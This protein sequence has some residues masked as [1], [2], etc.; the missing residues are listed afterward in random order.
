MCSAVNSLRANSLN[1]LGRAASHPE[2]FVRPVEELTE[3]F[4]CFF[5]TNSPVNEQRA[6]SMPRGKCGVTNMRATPIGIFHCVDQSCD[7]QV[8]QRSPAHDTRFKRGVEAQIILAR[9]AVVALERRTKHDHLSMIEVVRP[10]SLVSARNDLLPCCQNGS[11]RE[12]QL[13]QGPL[14]LLG[15]VAHHQVVKG[16][17]LGQLDLERRRH[18]RQRKWCRSRPRPRL[19]RPR[20]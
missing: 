3:Q 6:A 11:N 13:G 18:L 15:S 17:V 9:E 20:G 4:A 8:S 2:R 1:K 19:T 14:R 7:W 12:V 10:H 5:P 16:V